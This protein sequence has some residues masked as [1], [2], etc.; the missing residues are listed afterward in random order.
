[1]NKKLTLNQ[2][3]FP[4]HQWD[5][6]NRWIDSPAIKDEKIN[7]V[8]LV[9]YFEEDNDGCKDFWDHQTIEEPETLLKQ[10]ANINEMH[11]WI[12]SI[13]E[14]MDLWCGCMGLNLWFETLDNYKDFIKTYDEKHRLLLLNY[15]DIRYFEDT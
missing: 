8:N 2:S 5:T 11:L 3:D 9:G 7:L 15:A 4:K 10:I 6:I 12:E 13:D 14:W 1:M